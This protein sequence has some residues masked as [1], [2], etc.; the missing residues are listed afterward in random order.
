MLKQQSHAGAPRPG[1]SLTYATFSQDY[2]LPFARL[3][4]RSWDR[5]ESIIRCHLNPRIGTRLLHEISVFD[6][7]QLQQELVDRQYQPATCDRILVMLRYS[8]NKAVEWQLLDRNPAGSVKPFRQDH[9][10]ERYLTGDE[11]QRLLNLLQT[12]PNRRVCLLLLFLLCT[13]ARRGEVF[14]ACWQQVDLD[15]QRWTIPAS[16]AKSKKARTLPLNV[17]A[18]QVLR[19]VMRLNHA[20]GWPAQGRF[21]VFVNRSGK[22]YRS[23]FK[24][25]NRIRKQAGIP[26]VRTH[27][28]RHQYASMLVNKGRSLYEVQQL[29]G[30]ADPKMTMRYAHLSL[31]ALQRAS[32]AASET[33]GDFDFL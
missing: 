10:R 28:L 30:H 20:V 21:P 15:V 32:N 8:L 9:S 4:K 22:A 14:K 18:M 7:Q 12:H 13:G 6:V 26:D 23:I 3:H 17:S 33:L 2:Y 5:D 31:D 29:L 1:Q 16:H 24:T 25:W 11:L 27:D 19:E